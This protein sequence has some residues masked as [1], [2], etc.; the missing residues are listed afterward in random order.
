MSVKSEGEI[1][2]A[3]IAQMVANPELKT[4]FMEAMSGSTE[5]IAQFYIKSFNAPPE[6]ANSLAAESGEGLWKYIGERVCVDLW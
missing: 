6:L 5:E 3:G 2:N 4:Q 1:I